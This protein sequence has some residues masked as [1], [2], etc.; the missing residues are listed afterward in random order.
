MYKRQVTEAVREAA[1]ASVR[2]LFGTFP[3]DVPLD[4]AVVDS[5]D[6]VG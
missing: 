5:Y 1:A 2:L 3:V 4:V 6:Q